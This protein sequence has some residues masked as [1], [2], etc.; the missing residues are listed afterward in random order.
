MIQWVEATGTD[1]TVNY[2]DWLKIAFALVDE[3]GELAAAYFHRISKFYPKYTHEECEKKY[4]KCVKT[5]GS[6]VKIEPL[7]HYAKQAGYVIEPKTI[8]IPNTEEES[9]AIK[10]S[11]KKLPEFSKAIFE[12]L[13]NFF[14]RAT[15]KAN[16]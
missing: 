12:E 8:Q 9:N 2:D 16:N 11:E 13:L 14:K 10:I 4:S 5:N 7:F 1:L 3:F 6:G 15:E